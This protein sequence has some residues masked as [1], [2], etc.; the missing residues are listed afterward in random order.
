MFGRLQIDNRGRME[1]GPRVLLRAEPVVCH[2]ATGPRGT[3]LIGEGVVIEHGAG[4]AAH[5]SVRI[6]AGAR[7]GPY[8]LVMDTTFHD[9]EDLSK[10]PDPRPV[11]I[12]EG[13]VIGSHATVLPGARIGAGARVLAGSVVMGVV[14]PGAQVR[15]IVRSM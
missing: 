12:G 9:P 11:V 2:L 10:M 13:A 3:L 8:A 4:V 6:G 7:I 14:P 5:L 15:G 1:I